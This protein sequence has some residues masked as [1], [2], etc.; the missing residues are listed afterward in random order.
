MLKMLKISLLPLLLLLASHS[1]ADAQGKSS[2][3]QPTLGGG[4][5]F[6]R[7]IPVDQTT[8][9]DD[10]S[11]SVRTLRNQYW[12]KIMPEPRPG[13]GYV[14]YSEDRSSQGPEITFLPGSIWVRAKFESYK[15][16]SPTS[17]GVYT[18]IRLRVDKVIGTDPGP[19]PSAI[20]IPGSVVDL[21]V[22]GGMIRDASGRLHSNLGV[23][24]HYDQLLPQHEYL[25]QLVAAPVGNFY[26][27]GGAWD[28]SSGSATGVFSSERRRAREGRSKL[29]GSQAGVAESVIADEIRRHSAL[30][31]GGAHP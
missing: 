7:E 5:G 13:D 15:V 21:G 14:A 17:V 1:S 3:A 11:E 2:S 22:I 28:V 6:W 9:V 19:Q 4:V 16:F 26:L 25:I 18:E 30:Q 31:G 20:P 23:G 24:L 8:Q 10:V 29:S 12:A 27:E